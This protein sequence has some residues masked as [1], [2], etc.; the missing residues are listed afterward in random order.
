M[1]LS[2]ERYEDS[3]GNPFPA[4]KIDCLGTYIHLGDGFFNWK[5]GDCQQ[6]ESSRS[7]K[8]FGVVRQ[9]CACCK[10]SL[11]VRTDSD[12][13]TQTI[14]SAQSHQRELATANSGIE[15]LQKRLARFTNQED[16][17]DRLNGKVLRLQ[18]ELKKA[19][20]VGA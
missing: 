19:N 3:N 9:C 6:E 13:I 14:D 20:A 11:L 17:I 10:Y 4:S 8:G 2:Q 15:L 16:E 12:F 18:E 1:F 7:F 5:C